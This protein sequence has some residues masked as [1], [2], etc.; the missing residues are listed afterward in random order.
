MIR[1]MYPFWSAMVS[2]LVAQFLKPF[3]YYAVTRKWRW[4]LMFE[5]GGFP[6]SHSA[7]VTAL[8]LSVGLQEQF[9]SAIFAVTLSLAVVVMYDAANVR[10]YSGQNIRITQQLLRDLKNET[11]IELDDPIYDTKVK[12]V[13]GHKWREVIGGMLLGSVIALLFHYYF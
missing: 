11:D 3:I 1:S 7:L 8:A 9:R 2:A 6:S 10:Y 12:E 4:R 13:L 5:S